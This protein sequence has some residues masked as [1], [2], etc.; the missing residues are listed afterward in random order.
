MSD[1]TAQIRIDI[2]ATGAEQGARRVNAA[3]DG[4]GNKGRSIGAANDNLR[5]TFDRLGGS[6][7]GAAGHGS[8]LG[9]IF[10]NIRGRAAG[11]APEI[12]NLT[13]T[14]AKFGPMAAVIGGV[15]LAIGAVSA[16][17]I[18]AAS[19][20]EM[21]KANLLTITGSSQKAEESYAALVNFATKTPFDLG[22]AVEGFTKLRTLGLQATEK[23]L[24]SF[25]NTAAAMGKPLSQMIEAVADAATGEFE[26]LKEF[27]IKSKQEGDKVKFTF[28]G[29]TTS[30]GKDAASIQK[31]LEDLGNSK[32]GGAMA[33]QMDT[34]KGA[35]SNVEDAVFQAFAAIGGG[36]LGA[37]FKEMLKSISAGVSAATP[38]LASI[39]NV[40]GSIVGAVGN[41]LNSLGNMWLAL[42]GGASS[43]TTILTALTVTFNLVAKGVEVFGNVV[44]AVFGAFAPLI[45]GVRMLFSDGFSSLLNWMGVS[46]ET[47]GRSWTN[48]IVGI[49]RGVAFVVGEMPKLFS[50]AINDVMGMFRNLG[51][52]VSKIMSAGSLKDIGSALASIPGVISGSFNNTQ[53]ALDATARRA[54]AIAA[55]QKGAAAAIDRLMGK[56]NVKAKLDTG[57][58][59][60]P[61]PDGK[62]KDDKDAEKKAKQEA[63]FWKTLQGELETAKL[64]PIEAENHRKELELQKILGRDINKGEQE[65]IASIMAQT[66]TAKFLTAALDTHNQTSRDIA[67]QET[68][69]RLKMNGA[70]EE[71]VALE[72]KVADFRNNALRQGVDIQSDAYKASEL[73]LRVDEARLGVLKKQN[74]AFDEQTAKLKDMAKTGF[75][76][77]NDALSTHGSVAD[78]QGAAKEDYKKTLANLNAALNSKD[79]DSKLSPAAFAAGV[80]KAGEDFRET[81][82]E[83]GTDFSQKMGKVADLLGSIGGAIGGKVGKL[84]SGAG[85]L[86]KNVGDF[87]KTQNDIQDKFTKAFGNDSPFVKGLGKAVGGAVAG[88][89]ISENIMALSKTLGIKLNGTGAKIGG[90]LGGVV[91]GPLG[92][93]IGSIGGGI[94]GNLFKKTKYGTATLTGAGDP[95][96]SGRGSAQKKAASGLA[97]SVQEGL[98][99][100]ASQLGG[101]LGAYNVS[102]GMY[103]DKYRVSTT[104]YGGKLGGQGNKTDRLGIV[105]FGKDGEAAAIQYAIEDA[106]KD[107]AITGLTPIIQKALQGLGADSAIQ[108]AKDWSAAMDDYKS[109]IDPVGAA[110]DS[111]IKPLDNLKKTMLQVGASS[112]DMAKF[113]DYRSKK[114]TAALK[115][116]VSGFQSLLDDLN[117]DT[118]GVTALNQL[119][120]NLDK[121]NAFKSDLAAGK[122]V[123]QDAFT[124]LA[125]SIMGNAGDVYATNSTQYQ[126]LVSQIKALTGNAITNA[127]TSFNTAAGTN[128]TA[129]AIADQTNAIT[130]Q[131]GITNDYLRQI[132]EAVNSGGMLTDYMG[133]NSNVKVYNGRLVQAY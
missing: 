12:A 100:L 59:V 131:Q 66:R 85:D 32:F 129:A 34:I 86:A 17:A 22:Q 113:E 112:E 56:N 115:E 40:I 90:A 11:A 87:G 73:I 68:A 19:K 60:K 80:K 72:M 18:D 64:L 74:T 1:A 79:K 53:K 126:D 46:F 71:Q 105:D 123:D 110:V 2:V 42:H 35:M 118:G 55:D 9:A 69:L 70:T 52:V 67:D 81:M 4:I 91:G 15:A 108:F 47:G 30:V 120:S 41:V 84:V 111:I 23:A 77:G 107:G 130:S 128:N 25:G 97:G 58:I 38:M 102:I 61:K 101:Q 13:G 27:G 49:M 96:V 82:A 45:N 16:K 99:N 8:K 124:S 133:G 65:R 98:A 127:T 6:M 89:K 48:S 62:K 39:G 122:T 26:R 24:M 83:I 5:G 132:A 28:G 121:L 51:N 88:L 106:I 57:S 93:I 116:Q 125:Q 21:W 119:T 109:M 95:V 20:V 63:D 31:Y 36:Q 104:G 44:A 92:S 54:N 3:L 76:F 103:K 33:R 117:G 75:S 10:E 78:R 14:L 43:G 7:G 94:L 114:L 29:V 37:S 50:I